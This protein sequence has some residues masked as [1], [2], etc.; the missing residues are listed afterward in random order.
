MDRETDTGKKAAQ[1]K[2]SLKSDGKGA[3]SLE[4]RVAAYLA[5]KKGSKS[6]GVFS[7]ELGMPKESLSR[8]LHAEQSMTLATLQKISSV[9]GVSTEEILRFKIP[10]T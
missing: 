5:A 1:A 6:L 9:L 8:Y 4:R 2:S 3:I 7:R 10:R